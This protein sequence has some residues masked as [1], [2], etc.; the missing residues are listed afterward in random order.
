MGNNE[1]WYLGPSNDAIGPVSVNE[2]K[3]LLSARTL[4]GGSLVCKQDTESWIQSWLVDCF[5]LLCFFFSIASLVFALVVPGEREEGPLL[6]SP[7]P[8]PGGGFPPPPPLP[9]NF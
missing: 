2:L 4:T 8:R 1:W 9:Q 5:P 7:L 3:S 6:C